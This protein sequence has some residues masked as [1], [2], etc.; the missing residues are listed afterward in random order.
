M[1]WREAGGGHQGGWCTLRPQKMVRE[2][3]LHS[4]IRRRQ[5]KDPGSVYNY[6]MG[7]NTKYESRLLQDI[8]GE[9]MRDSAGNSVCI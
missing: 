7:G 9:R 8:H 4:H 1:G 5:R 6:P 3:R 2:L